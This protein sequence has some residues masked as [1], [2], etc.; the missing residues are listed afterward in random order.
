M[1]IREFVENLYNNSPAPAEQMGT[2]QA[3]HDLQNFRENGWDLPD[4]I[5]VKRYRDAWNELVAE[6]E[7]ERDA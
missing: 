3:Y 5:T 1:T 7:A 4:G 2:L 6:M